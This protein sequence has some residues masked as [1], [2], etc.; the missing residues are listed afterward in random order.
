[1]LSRPRISVVMA[2]KDGEPYLDQALESV[3][4]QTTPPDEIVVVDGGS[5]DRSVEIA[6][7]YARVRCVEQVGSG[8]AGA[9]NEGVAVAR[10]ELL[11]FNDSDD[12]WEPDKLEKQVALLAQHAEVDYAISLVRFFLEPGHSHPPSFRPEL[13][14]G[15]HV[16]HMPSALLIR[17]PAFE[18]VGPFRADLIVA[19]DLDWFARAKDLPLTVGTVRKVLVHKRVHEKNLSYTSSE[20]MNPELL[21]LLR[22]SVAR[23]RR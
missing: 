4:G 5:N 23:R 11:A 21:E 8:F 6:T 16:A 1:V 18:Q 13:L 12:L 19:N 3:V 10:G 14:E 15:E 20:N 7:S 17:R 9:W 2:V 22:H